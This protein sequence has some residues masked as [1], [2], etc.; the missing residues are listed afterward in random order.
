[1]R[2]DISSQPRKKGPGQWV[3]QWLVS[4]IGLAL[5]SQWVSGVHLHAQG[6]SAA[7]IVLG[8]SA[9]LGLLNLLLKPL[10]IL[11]TLPV[12]ILTLGLF[13]LAVNAIVL[14]A[15]VALVPDLKIDGFWP[16]LWAA[17][18][19]SLSSLILNALVGSN[20]VRI[21]RDKAG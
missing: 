1:M 13:T 11:I 9:V 6:L 12:N 21:Q 2:I 7:V 3:T 8:A 4:A 10:I 15:A 17:L 20:H 19:I 14:M 18:V 5:A 16:A